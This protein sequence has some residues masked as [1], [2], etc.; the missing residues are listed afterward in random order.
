MKLNIKPSKNYIARLAISIFGIGI[1]SLAS[2][3]FFLTD[4]GADPYQVLCNAIHTQFSI[5]IGMANMILNGAIVILI[6]IFFRKHINISMF[7][8]LILSGLF[9]DGYVALLDPIVNPYLHM[10]VKVVIVIF[11]CILLSLGV[12]LYTAPSLGASPADSVGLII[13]ELLKKPYSIIRIF[14]D[15]LYTATG[16][17]LGGKVGITTIISVILTGVMIGI[18]DK[19]LNNTRLLRYIKP[20]QN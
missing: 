19:F 12:Y 5:T 2:A 20:V 3:L 4:L 16:F 17:L 7:L 10:V 9:I 15:V 11:A 8:S 18:F 1:I 14:T 13:A 6:L